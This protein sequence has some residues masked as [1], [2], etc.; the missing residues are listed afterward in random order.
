MLKHSDGTNLVDNP[1]PRKRKFRKDVP[2]TS[3]IL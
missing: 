3:A 1:Y 2:M